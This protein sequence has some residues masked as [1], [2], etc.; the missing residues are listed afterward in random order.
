MVVAASVQAWSP[1]ARGAGL[2]FAS[3]TMAT[4]GI[5]DKRRRGEA[6]AREDLFA[7]GKP[8]EADRRAKRGDDR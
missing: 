5:R 8:A 2:A 4:T 1:D 6:V 7:A 3:L